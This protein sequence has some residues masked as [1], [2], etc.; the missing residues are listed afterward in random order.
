MKLTIKRIDFLKMLTY[1]SQA[2][3]SRSAETQYLNYLIEVTADGVSV[4]ASDGSISAKVTQSL[5]DSK[6]NDVIFSTAEGSIQTPA[7]MLLDIISKLGGEIVTLDMVDTGLLNISDDASNFNLVTKDGSEYPN[8]S[9]FIPE[10]NAG[11]T[12]PLKD[13]KSL[14]DTTSYAVSTKGNELYTG[15]NVKAF[16]GTLSFI[17]TDGFRLASLSLPEQNQDANFN[18]TCPVKSL[19]MATRIADD[20][21]C[22]IYLDDQRALF[23]S[24]NVMISTRLLHGDFLNTSN[25]IPSSYP[26]MFKISTVEFL[27]AADRVK[28][29]SSADNSRTSQV[30]LTISRDNGA[31]LSAKSSNY[32]NSE[33]RLPVYDLAMPEGTDIFE[34]YF[35]V[36]YAIDA[37][38]ALRSDMIVFALNGPTRSVFVKN[39]NPNNIQLF[40][41]ITAN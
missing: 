25:L 10:G 8:V 2:I 18:F 41:P 30:K 22:T 36:D 31:T 14:F 12:V 7:K 40:Q 29:I 38:K 5:K 9:L 20:G 11:F 39:D 19:D 23:V 35:N 1:A 16:E 28:I 3:P 26:Y 13:L 37:V 4:I 6:G 24:E 17:A 21:E 34:I 27:S 32:G 33:E 15:I